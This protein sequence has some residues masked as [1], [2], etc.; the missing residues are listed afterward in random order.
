[1]SLDV[2]FSKDEYI[3]QDLKRLLYFVLH[4]HFDQHL[5]NLFLKILVNVFIVHGLLK[6]KEQQDLKSKHA[7]AN[8][9]HQIIN[10]SSITIFCVQKIP[11]R[12][13]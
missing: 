9:K 7:K 8:S 3:K 6:Y 2:L 5:D 10:K 4:Y 11:F 12:K 1:M 13:L